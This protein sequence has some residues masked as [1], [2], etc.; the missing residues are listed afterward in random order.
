[1]GQ[2]GEGIIYTL[3][4]LGMPLGRLVSGLPQARPEKTAKIDGWMY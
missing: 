4:G 2:H 3:S 1:M